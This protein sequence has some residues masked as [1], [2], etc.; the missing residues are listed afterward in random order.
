MADLPKRKKK[1]T[2][3]R[4]LP[5]NLQRALETLA[6]TSLDPATKRAMQDVLNTAANPDHG[7]PAVIVRSLP[8]DR[9]KLIVKT[10]GRMKSIGDD[11]IDRGK[12]RLF[13]LSDDEW[14]VIVNEQTD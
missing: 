6:A 12:A 9:Q 2:H 13:G 5:A 7:K 1:R 4:I 3:L 10:A 11:V 8:E 14:D